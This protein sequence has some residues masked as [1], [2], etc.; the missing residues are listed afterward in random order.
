M[1]A[2]SLK[3]R[4]AHD[5]DFKRRAI[6]LAIRSALPISHTAKELGLKEATL[7]QWVR[8]H[9]K[10]FSVKSQVSGQTILDELTDLKKAFARVK[11][12]RDILK[13]AAQYFAKESQR[14]T[15]S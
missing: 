2:V 11:E 9:K 4:K 15:N 7:Y 8:Q 3:S 6:D 14:G 10:D 5:K 12:E 13:K 1:S